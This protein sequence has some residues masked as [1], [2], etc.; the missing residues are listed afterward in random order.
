MRHCLCRQ[1][2][3]VNADDAKNLASTF[4]IQGF[5]TIK[6]FDS[7]AELDESTGQVSRKP[8]DYNGARTKKAT[9]PPAPTSIAG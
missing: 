8:Q 3:G 7:P 4:G 9:P 5:P 2:A 1:I 6:Y